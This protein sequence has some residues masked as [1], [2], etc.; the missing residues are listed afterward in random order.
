M[1]ICS[2]LCHAFCS[3]TLVLGCAL[4]QI[5]SA[6]PPLVTEDAGTLAK[7]QCQLEFENRR[8]RSVNEQ[9]LLPACNFFLDMELQLG[10]LRASPDGA[11]TEKRWLLQAKKT[12][13]EWEKEGIALGLAVGTIKRQGQ[14]ERENYATLPLT[15]THEQTTWSLN[16][17][18]VRNNQEG[19]WKRFT[20]AAVEQEINDRWTLV[21]EM[22]KT[23]DE[24]TTLQGG[25]RYWIV[26]KKIQ[27][28]GSVGQ[29]RGLGNEGR[30]TSLGIRF[31]TE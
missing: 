11:A 30:W 5:A 22:F 9:D 17:G 2:R 7:G 3:F 14:S 28:T 24:A 8:F 15:G 27:L 12:L 18:G 20:A 6:A 23:Q 16:L 19:R 31:E 10:F 1:S 21:G 25:F 4:P 13:V 26:S 29:Q